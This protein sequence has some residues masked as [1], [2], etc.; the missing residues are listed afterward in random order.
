[1]M[2]KWERKW[3]RSDAQEGGSEAA[4]L[5]RVRNSSLVERCC[6]EDP[7]GLKPSTEAAGLVALGRLGGRG[8]FRDRLKADR[9]GCWTQRKRAQGQPR[10]K[11]P[12][13][14]CQ[15]KPRGQDSRR[16]Y[17]KPT[18]VAGHLTC[19]GAR[20]SPRQGTRQNDPVTSG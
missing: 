12:S 13:P 5:K 7:T 19:Q 18:Q 20:E 10:E 11:W 8:A 3:H 4:I 16:P 14:R 6:A 9:K 1:M 2:A 15:E 17:R